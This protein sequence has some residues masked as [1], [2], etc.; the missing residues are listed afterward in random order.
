MAWS[1]FHPGAL[2]AQ[3]VHGLGD[4]EKRAYAA[5]FPVSF[6][7]ELRGTKPDRKVT[8]RYHA[9]VEK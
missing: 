6:F 1:D 9:A 2:M 3:A 5:P 4:G 8:N 7:L